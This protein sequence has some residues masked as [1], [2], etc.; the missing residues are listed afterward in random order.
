MVT[1]KAVVEAL[2]FASQKPLA[3]KEIAGAL[4]SAAESFGEGVEAALGKASESEIGDSLRLLQSE[5]SELRPLVP[6][7]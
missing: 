7:C 4:K 5:Y 1:L 2:L 6:A 3:L